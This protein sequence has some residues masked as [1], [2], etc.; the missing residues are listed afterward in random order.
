MINKALEIL[1]SN[2]SELKELWSLAEISY[3]YSKKAYP[4]EIKEAQ[5]MLLELEKQMQNLIGSECKH[6]LNNL[7]KFME[8]IRTE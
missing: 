6:N 3:F 5:A 2:Y 7:V 1:K 4:K 8:K